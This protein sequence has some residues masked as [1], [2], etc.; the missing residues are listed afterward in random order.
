MNLLFRTLRWIFSK[1]C[2]LWNMQYYHY[3]GI[4][5]DVK[6]AASFPGIVKIVFPSK[7]KIGKGSVINAGAVIHCAG[8]VSIGTHVHIGHG[9]CVYSTNHD[10]ASSK[11]IPYDTNNIVKPVE[12]GDCVWIGANVSILPGVQVG[13]GAIIGMGAVVTQ[14]V[15]KGVIMGGNPAKVIGHRDMDTYF[16]LKNEGKFV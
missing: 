16:R 10:Y 1:I 3:S 13:E 15:E 12:V 11:G 14:N 6:F 9:F 7:C 8:G 5:Q 4:D 2:H